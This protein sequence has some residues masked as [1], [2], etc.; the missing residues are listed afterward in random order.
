LESAEL[1]KEA[2]RL[3]EQ[4]LLGFYT[5]FEV[6]EVFA[7]APNQSNQPI[8]VFTLVVAEERSDNV[9]NSFNYLTA[10]GPVRLS[11][12][13]HWKFGACRYL[14]EIGDLLPELEKSV[15]KKFWSAS[16]KALK[17]TADKPIA[18][19]FVPPDSLKELPFNR[20]LKNNFWNGSY[21]LEWYDIQKG[22]LNPL[23]EDPRRL[24][25]LSDDLKTYTSVSLSTLSDRLGNIVLQLPVR[26]LMSHIS[27]AQ[28]ESFIVDV[29]W[30]PKANP[31]SLRVNIE[32]EFDGAMTGYASQLLDGE[33]TVIQMPPGSGTYKGTIWDEENN[34]VL[35]ATGTSN[36]IRS[37][38]F[39]MTPMDPEPRTFRTND[40][41]GH[42]TE[43]RINLRSQ[44]T[45]SL[46]GHEEKYE[47][48]SRKRIY[49]EENAKL[50]A[51][52][53]F[54]QY[55]PTA[56]S[57][58]QNHENALHDIRTLINDHGEDGA[59]LWDPYLD[60]RDIIETLFF[61]PFSGADLR[62]LTASKKSTQSKNDDKEL[63]QERQFDQAKGNLRGLRLEFR[64]TKGTAFSGFHDRFLIF[65]R[66]EDGAQVWSLGTSVNSLGMA[67]HILQKVDD[68]QQV[69]DAFVSLWDRLSAPENL[70]WKSHH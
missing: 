9:D 23:F 46:I 16:G 57:K 8:N 45:K 48:W 18:P 47:D 53:R 39:N 12:L 1:L 64:S 22:A 19:Q 61:C 24:Q 35:A 65:P 37:I 43:Q 26:A 68:G 6:T 56:G 32:R 33:R 55:T 20:V 50:K 58:L 3:T 13:E 38:A 4:G 66:K 59:W 21:V 10:D 70:I 40:K 14:R 52:R 54:V 15:D 41:N 28:D 31:R 49:R 25:E 17:H 34:I 5:H 36:W 11:S 42:W 63:T 2:K 30:H 27:V 29:C 69:M 67:H 62:A 44:P 60:A 7:F 51:Q